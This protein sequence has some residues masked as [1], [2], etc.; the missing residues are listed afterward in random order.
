MREM[1]VCMG[2]QDIFM[3]SMY[4]VIPRWYFIGTEYVKNKESHCKHNFF[5]FIPLLHEFLI[6]IWRTKLDTT[7][8]CWVSYA[9]SRFWWKACR[10][11]CISVNTKPGDASWILFSFLMSRIAAFGLVRKQMRVYECISDKTFQQMIKLRDDNPLEMLKCETLMETQFA[12]IFRLTRPRQEVLW[13]FTVERDG[14]LV[15]CT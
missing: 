14:R 6:Q 1:F 15:K 3:S 8:Y 7:F 10:K 5:R 13:M 2:F 4:V 11:I 12:T 9:E